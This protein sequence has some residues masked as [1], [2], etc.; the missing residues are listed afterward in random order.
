MDAPEIAEMAGA[1][2]DRALAIGFDM[3]ATTAAGQALLL[4]KGVAAGGRFVRSLF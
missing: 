4:I 1:S 2:G 3:G